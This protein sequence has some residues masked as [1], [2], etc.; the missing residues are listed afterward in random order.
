VAWLLFKG[1]SLST[2]GGQFAREVRFKLLIQP[3]L[4]AM[5]IVWACA[6]GL[7]GGKLPAI[8]AARPPRRPRPVAG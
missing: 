1:G 5:G 6:I 2:I 3:P 4:I 7:I 8:R